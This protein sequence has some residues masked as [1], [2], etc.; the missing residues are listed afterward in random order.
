[1][2]KGYSNTSNNRDVYSG[3]HCGENLT[4]EQADFLK[5]LV[6]TGIKS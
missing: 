6:E 4:E 5:D 2:A 1:M 3:I